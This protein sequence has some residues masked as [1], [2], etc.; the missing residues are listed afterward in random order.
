MVADEFAAGKYPDT[1][2]F[3]DASKKGWDA[4]CN[5]I[6][7]NERQMVFSGGPVTYKSCGIKGALLAV[8]SLL[9]NHRHVTAQ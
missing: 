2:I 5:N 3:T 6:S 4:I 9:K 7:Q 1:I 8:Q